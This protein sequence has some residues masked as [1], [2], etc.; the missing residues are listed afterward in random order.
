MDRSPR[1]DTLVRALPKTDD[2]IRARMP[3]PFK[4]LPLGE[5]F[6]QRYVPPISDIHPTIAGDRAKYADP[7]YIKDKLFAGGQLDAAI[8]VCP[9]RLLRADR[10]HEAAVMKATN[11][12]LAE[13]WLEADTEDR[14]WGSI[15][16]SPANVDASVKEIERWGQHPKFVQIAVPLHVHMPYGEEEY[17]PIWEA[18][19]ARKLPVAIHGDGGGGVEYDATIAGPPTQFLE[20]HTLFPVNAMVHLTSLISEGVFD[21]LAELKVVFTDGAVGVLIPFLW[22]EDAKLKSLKEEVPW[23][24]RPPSDTIGTQVRF[25]LRSDDVPA[26]PQG[27][28]PILNLK[29][30]AAALM[31]G[32]NFPMWDMMPL[33]SDALESADSHRNDLMGLNALNTYARLK[34]SFASA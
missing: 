22:R 26:P 33:A 12:W 13:T 4:R 18:A 27:L 1:I 23:V 30:A 10:R 20:Y 28:G 5:L 25:V 6:G 29:G 9:N 31:Y 19:A 7:A 17:F 2:E 16:V 8:L 34:D 11:E 32:S 3:Q 14:V 15:Y 24:R 21:R